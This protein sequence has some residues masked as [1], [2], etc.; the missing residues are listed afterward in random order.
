MGLVL[1]KPPPTLRVLMSDEPKANLHPSSRKQEL[2]QKVEHPDQ[3]VIDA[4]AEYV[5]RSSMTLCVSSD[6]LA[7]LKTVH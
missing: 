5:W 2:R 6:L 4:L 1:P 7:M 3:E